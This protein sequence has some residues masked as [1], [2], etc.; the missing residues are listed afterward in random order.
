M[1]AYDVW[2]AQH[3]LMCDDD[4]DQDHGSW[5][6]RKGWGP[7]WARHRNR[8][9]KQLLLQWCCAVVLQDDGCLDN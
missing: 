1:T 3:L 5:K 6:A 9:V 4:A 8:I 7:S 2:S